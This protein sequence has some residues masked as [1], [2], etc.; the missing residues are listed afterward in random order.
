MERRTRPHLCLRSVSRTQS[1][2]MFRDLCMLRAL[3]PQCPDF[4]I[5]HQ[6]F[7]V[8]PERKVRALRSHETQT[9]KPEHRGREVIYAHTQIFHLWLGVRTERV[10]QTLA[11]INNMDVLTCRLD[12]FSIVYYIPRNFFRCG[13]FYVLQKCKWHLH[14][15]V[16]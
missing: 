10:N 6:I 8:S 16:D 3:M 13:D 14:P 9:R 15:V 4:S 12:A 7:I 5:D 11:N 2:H 1:L